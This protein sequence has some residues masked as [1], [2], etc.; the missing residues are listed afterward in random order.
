MTSSISSTAQDSIQLMMQQMFK[1]MNAADTDGSKG[2][3]LD[4]L[5]SIDTSGDVGGAAF[6][7][8]LQ[9]QFDTLDAD[10][11]GELS[12][13]EIS[14][15]KPPEPMGPPPGLSLESSDDSTTADDLVAGIS[16]TDSSSET[17]STDSLQSLIKKL[18]NDF[19]DKFEESYSNVDSDKAEEAKKVAENVK[20][21]LSKADS[22]Q[23]GKLSLDEL[24]AV[25]TSDNEQMAKFVSDLKEKFTQF[26][27]NGD[28][29]LSSNELIAAVPKKQ[30]STQEIAALS[31]SLN[32]S[33]DSSNSSSSS[34]ISNTSLGDLTSS[35]VQKLLNS[36]Q[37]SGIS[38]LASTVGVA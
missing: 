20:A 19:L 12:D 21:L 26:D 18:L 22:N 2:L 33:S 4:E 13:A 15:A 38:S 24:S 28:G 31:E 29:L 23:D 10:G 9:E 27:S 14:A 3:S 30:F 32:S 11:N 35:F 16:E 17:D 1:K 5:S 8:S 36:Y 7:K 34:N 37:S 25:D 6:L